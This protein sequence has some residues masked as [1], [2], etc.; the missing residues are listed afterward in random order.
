MKAPLLNIA[1]AFS[2]FPGPRYRDQGPWSGEQF[3]EEHLLPA[4]ESAREAGGR[5]TIQLDGVRYGYP[6]AFLEEAFG[7]LARRFGAETVKNVLRFESDEEPAL[8]D[9]IVHYIDACRGGN[10]GCL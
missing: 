7:G 10:A 3:L 6:A 4:F 5:M 8:R 1:E 2:E 9:E